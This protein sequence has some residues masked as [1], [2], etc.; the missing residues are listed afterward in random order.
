[1]ELVVDDRIHPSAEV[2]AA[3][4]YRNVGRR[5]TRSVRSSD[6]SGSAKVYKCRRC[7]NITRYNK[8]TC[9][10]HNGAPIVR[11]SQLLGSTVDLEDGMDDARHDNAEYDVHSDCYDENDGE[12]GGDASGGEASVAEASDDIAGVRESGS[13]ASE[14]GGEA[15]DLPPDLSFIMT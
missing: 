1:M 9:R 7:G 10:R 4:Q 15:A 11:V 14:A 5:A 12:C 6:E 13:G 2:V 8:R 3:P